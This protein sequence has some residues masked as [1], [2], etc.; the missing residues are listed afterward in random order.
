[1]NLEFV[2]SPSVVSR[3]TGRE[4]GGA[5]VGEP[6][7]GIRPAWPEQS[8]KAPLLGACTATIHEVWSVDQPLTSGHSEGIAWRRSEGLLFGVIELHETDFTSSANC[9]SL[10]AA[11]EE[12]Y[13]RIFRLLDAEQL[14]HLWRVWNYLA[15]INLET[16]GLERYRQFNIGRQDAFLECHRGATGNVPAACAIGLAGSPLSIAFMA[17]RAPAV[18]L[19]NPRQV[20]A[21]N[22]PADYGPRS[23]TFSR[24]AL[25]YLP[26]QELLFISG[27]ASIVGHQ[28]VSPGDVSGQCRESMANIAAVVDEANRLCRSSPYILSELSYRVYVRHAADFPLLREVLMPLIGDADA[29]FVQA[30]ICRSDLLL[31]I[32]A[33]ASHTLEKS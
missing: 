26:A 17:G 10:Q 16:N 30:D 11:S 18:P 14:P 23:P 1:M 21:Y 13:R 29:V 3:E 22:Y 27:T 33:F 25:A 4:L 7:G 15:E 6:T 28:T 2:S 32:E 19:E 20:S 12:A 8:V 24:G 31:E 9:S 5:M